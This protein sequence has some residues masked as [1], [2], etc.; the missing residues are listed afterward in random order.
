MKNSSY[1]VA[2]MA[3]TKTSGKQC[4]GV[5]VPPNSPDSSEGRIGPPQLKP[6][7][8]AVGVDA[9]CPQKNPDYW[10][11]QSPCFAPATAATWHGPRPTQSNEQLSC[12]WQVVYY[13][14]ALATIAGKSLGN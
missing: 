7:M 10:E 6:L 2:A 4:C 14:T 13:G 1:L 5:I 8:P 12:L 11:V 3:C 9:F